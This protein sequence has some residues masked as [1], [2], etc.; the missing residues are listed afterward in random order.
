MEQRE[1]IKSIKDKGLKKFSNSGG[2]D[3]YS[4][5]EDN[6][7]DQLATLDSATDIADRDLPTR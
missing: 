3:I 6:L 4:D 7:R 2:N 1:L 5:H